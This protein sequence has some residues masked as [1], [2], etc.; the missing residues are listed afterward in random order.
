[1]FRVA[2][3]TSQADFSL[4]LWR[5]LSSGALGWVVGRSGERTGLLTPL[6][7][8]VTLTIGAQAV[9]LLL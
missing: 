4:F 5:V 1:M 2:T 8:Q 7:F 6:V 9:E 3:T